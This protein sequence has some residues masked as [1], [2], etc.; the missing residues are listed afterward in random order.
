S[1]IQLLL[2]QLACAAEPHSNRGFLDTKLARRLGAAP[3]LQAAK[4]ERSAERLRQSCNF[5]VEEHLDFLPGRDERRVARLGCF[6]TGLIPATPRGGPLC[7]LGHT[8]RNSMEPTGEGPI[9][10][11]RA[12]F[13][14]QDEEGGLESVL[15]IVGIP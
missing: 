15:G 8:I 10:T 9:G 14:R 12:A 7:V 1:S 4:E 13:A 5:F 11:K 3:V 6:H 2:E